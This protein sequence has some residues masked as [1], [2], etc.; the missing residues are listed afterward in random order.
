MARG[1][2]ASPN[3]LGCF[4]GEEFAAPFAQPW[5]RSKGRGK[6]LAQAQYLLAPLRLK[7]LAEVKMIN[8][9]NTRPILGPIKF[10][11]LPKK[12]KLIESAFGKSGS[13]KKP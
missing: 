4:T 1:H 6:S 8:T 12:R 10:R 2:P 7:V 3:Q 11:M 5:R 9:I 13:G